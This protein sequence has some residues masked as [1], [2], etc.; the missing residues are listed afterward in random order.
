MIN[1]LNVSPK[2]KMF[3]S[4][5][6]TSPPTTMGGNTK[7]MLEMINGS[8][9][10]VNFVVF[11]TEPETFRKNITKND[12]IKIIKVPY[13]FTKFS[14][15][16][17][18]Q[19]C[20]HIYRYLD[21][22]F[23]VHKLSKNDFFYSCSDFGPD[24]IPIFLLKRKYKF[25]WIASLYLFIPSPF[26]NLYNGYGF[27]F[28]KYIIYFIYQQIILHFILKESSYCFITN[29]HDVER[30]PKNKRKKLLPIYGGVN[31]NLVKKIGTYK[32]KKYDAVFCSRLHPQKGA[33]GLIDIWSNVVTEVPN[34]QLALI[35]NG[36]IKYEKY[37]RNKI[38]KLGLEKNITWF[39][40]VNGEKKYNIYMQS[41]VFLH[42]TIYDNNGMVAA[43]ALCS[44]LPV[45]MYDLLPLRK[46]YTLGCIKIK[47]KSKNIFAKNIVKIIS[48]QKYYELIKPNKETVNK[49]RKEWNWPSR[50]KIINNFLNI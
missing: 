8:I 13:S 43:E 10:R 25:K 12:Q 3:I 17:H 15:K 16:S 49:Y 7:I 23:S 26:E 41:K 19:E 38:A 18:I 46:I 22:Y 39:G 34:A 1:T 44:G 47:Q 21:K 27:P 42:T 48:N 14:F 24:V 32:Q 45:I 11:T 31:V 36:D 30:F 40:Y 50:I 28:L 33:S 9:D 35:G 20:I 5:I 2:S 6:Y 37:L 4:A 29:H